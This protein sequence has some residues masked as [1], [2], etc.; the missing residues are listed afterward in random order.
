MGFFFK[1]CWVLGLGLL[2]PIALPAGGINL[3]ESAIY[4]R[5][6]SCPLLVINSSYLRTS[7]I[8][9]GSSLCNLEVG[10]PLEVLRMWKAADGNTWFHVKVVS[11]DMDLAF[12]GRR[13]WVNVV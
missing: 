1:L 5:Q 11:R 2:V 6:S 10:T 7:P 13:G 9:T 8:P 3:H 12:E 4:R